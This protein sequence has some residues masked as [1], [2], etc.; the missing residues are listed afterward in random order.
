MNADEE[1]AEVA[2]VESR[3]RP[4]PS[5]EEA[6][7]LILESKF[8]AIIPFLAL[9]VIRCVFTY[10]S[11]VGLIVGIL[12]GVRFFSSKLEEQTN[13]YSRQQSKVL[14]MIALATLGIFIGLLTIVPVIFKFDL[15]CRLAMLP[16]NAD[17][18]NFLDTMWI[19]IVSDIA[20]VYIV[21]FVKSLVRLAVPLFFTQ[22]KSSLEAAR[23]SRYDIERGESVSSETTPLN[24]RR[25]DT[26]ISPN[27][28]LLP[29]DDYKRIDDSMFYLKHKR[30][31][32]WVNLISNAYRM[33]ISLPV[34]LCYFSYGAG[35]DILPFAYVCFKIAA[36][37]PI[38]HK[39]VECLKRQREG[40]LVSHFWSDCVV[41]SHTL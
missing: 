21:L 3:R 39:F 30:V 6:Q 16:M 31:V 24:S 20:I 22:C 33:L 36:V 18:L 14:W 13:L 34:W 38:F 4:L 41:L 9:L 7:A 28:A 17:D 26:S 15:W 1:V 27:T 37:T 5:V 12:A 40:L 35:S 23:S 10:A 8:R 29:N 2:N 19:C 11:R 32:L 25:R